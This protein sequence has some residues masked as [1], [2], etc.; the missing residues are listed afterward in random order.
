MKKY[1]SIYYLLF[2]LLI[3]GAFASMAQNR[4][5][6]LILG[7][8]AISF[9][10]LFLFQFINGLRKR[11]TGDAYLS[12][13]FLCLFVFSSIFALR[14]FYVHFENVE[15]VFGLTTFI[16]ILIYARKALLHYR[17]MVPKNKF[18]ALTILTF[19]LSI[20]FFLISVVVLTISP[21]LAEY[22]G[23]LAFVLLIFFVVSNFW[24]KELL[25][26]GENVTAFK[27]VGRMRDNSL[28]LI[29]LFFLFSLY[30]VL[31]R[32]RVLPKI[33]SDEFPQAYFDLIDNAELRKE[34]STKGS[35]KYQEF[36]E[37]Y[38]QFLKLNGIDK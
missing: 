35:Y 6:L 16:L 14:I 2:V 31:T 23:L 17:A 27:I 32:T 1:N 11:G 37:K 8:V 18:L 22:S 26:D 19:Y 29:S 28:L 7:V 4:Y 33:Y 5:G 34:P 12:I 15:L 30:A 10:L 36:K 25:I 9:S 21:R 20:I 13:E 24:K 3:M 38:D